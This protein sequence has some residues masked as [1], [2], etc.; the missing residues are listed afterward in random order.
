MAA[1]T[2]QVH[3]GQES[4]HAGAGKRLPLQHGSRSS[5][6]SHATLPNFFIQQV[7]NGQV[8][9]LST[10]DPAQLL[11]YERCGLTSP[12]CFKVARAVRGSGPERTR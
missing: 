8:I 11:A 10:L 6:G 2:A 7:P 1:I 12:R 3:Q 5:A 9:H 4:D